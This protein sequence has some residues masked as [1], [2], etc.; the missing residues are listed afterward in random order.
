[1]RAGWRWWWAL[2]CTLLGVVLA[3]P[4]LV[5]G[6]RA[7]RVGHTLEVAWRPRGGTRLRFAAVTLGHVI[8]GA[9]AEELERLRVHEQAH[10]RQFERWGPLL[11]VAYPW[12]SVV[13]WL[14]GE[15]AYWGNRF[16]REAR[17]AEAALVNAAPTT[18]SPTR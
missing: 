18:P 10:V 5:F 7:R 8:V 6:G 2:P 11:L 16:E 1:V 3:L 9:S 14:R 13:A 4:L 17:A 12:A 15:G